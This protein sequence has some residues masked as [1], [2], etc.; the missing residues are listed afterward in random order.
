MSNL[1]D[2]KYTA[3]IGRSY[4]TD[5]TVTLITNKG[6]VPAQAGKIL[7]ALTNAP[8]H[9]LTVQ[10]LIGTDAAGLDSKLDEVGLNT[11]QTPAKIWAFYKRRLI[12]QGF[13]TVS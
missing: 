12:D 10:Q 9:Q 1:I 6:K 3:P 13:I 4:N 8:D 11:V 2:T 7:E 5:A